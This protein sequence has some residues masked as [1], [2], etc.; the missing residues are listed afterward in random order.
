MLYRRLLGLRLLP[1]L[2]DIVSILPI[3]I[4]YPIAFF[5]T[6]GLGLNYL[7]S[8]EGGMIHALVPGVTLLLS[9]LFLKE[10]VNFLKLFFTTLSV[11]GVI[12]IFTMK[13]VNI[14]DMNILG[15][16]YA[17]LS[18]IVS[19]IYTLLAKSKLKKFNYNDLTYVMLFIG[20]IFLN[21]FYLLRT[22]PSS[23]LDMYFSP[24]TNPQYTLSV[25]YLGVFSTVLSSL[26]SNYSLTKLPASKVSVFNNLAT[27]ISIFAGT[28]VLNEPFYN[29]HFIGAVLILIGVIGVNYKK[30]LATKVTNTPKGVLNVYE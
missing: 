3:A 1:S 18:V 23:Y 24:L 2:S 8:S 12:F 5:I 9:S 20:F 28:I 30:E 27:L 14:T 29:Y 25:V 22:E 15:V 21:F 11:T 26:L 6:Q 16:V 13:N 19:S 7:T 4:C 10:K 17:S